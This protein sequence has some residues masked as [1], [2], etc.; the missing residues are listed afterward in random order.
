MRSIDLSSCI[1]G[2]FVRELKNRFLCEVL[3]SDVA[4]VCY[5]PSSC[6]LSNFISLQGKRVLLVPTSTPGS[7]TKLA[8]FAVPFKRSYII[9]NSSLANQAVLASINSRWFSFLGR[10]KHVLAEHKINNYKADLFI[11]DTK[12]IIEVKSVL[13]VDDEAI[14]PTVFSERS[15]EQLLAIKNLLAQGYLVHY[16][17]VSLNP[18]VKRIQIANGDAFH[19]QL[20]ECIGH[21]MTFSGHTCRFHENRISISKQVPIALDDL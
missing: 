9:L 15:L 12:T 17:I 10:R 21:G 1:E 6:H 5:V 3:V 8:L 7:R 14:F 19:T 20:L 13:A 4:T 16:C 18:Y 2:V 11:E